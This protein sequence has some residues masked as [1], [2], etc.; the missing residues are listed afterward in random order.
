MVSA[1]HYDARRGIPQPSAPHLRRRRLYTYNRIGYICREN[2][3]RNFF[4]FAV[5]GDSYFFLAPENDVFGVF[6]FCDFTICFATGGASHKL[7]N[8]KKRK[9]QKQHFQEQEKK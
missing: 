1:A 8:H 5:F 7:Q 6:V 2:I 4:F 3:I 9:H